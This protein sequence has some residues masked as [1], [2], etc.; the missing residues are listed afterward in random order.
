MVQASLQARTVVDHRCS[1]RS[2]VRHLCNSGCLPRGLAGGV[3]VIMKYYED[4][5]VCTEFET[6]ITH[7]VSADE[8][9]QFANN[10]DPWP[11]SFGRGACPRLHSAPS[12]LTKTARMW[13]RAAS[14]VTSVFAHDCAPRWI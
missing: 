7:K 1:Q 4:C 8:I 2:V 12:K 3:G 5:A 14:I 11:F 6:R 9:E 10:W 13:H